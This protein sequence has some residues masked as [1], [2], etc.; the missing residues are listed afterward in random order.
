MI[1]PTVVPNRGDYVKKQK[2]WDINYAIFC[3]TLFP[4]SPICSILLFFSAT[5]GHLGFVVDNATTGQVSVRVLPCAPVSIIPPLFH[6]LT[7]LV[8]YKHCRRLAN[9]SVVKKHFPPSYC[10]QFTLKH[11]RTM[12]KL[13]SNREEKKKLS[14]KITRTHFHKI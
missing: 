1:K 13:C 4:S 9:S 6:K 2:Q 3:R 12:S 5:P 10:Q 14:H 11:P 8:C 7:S